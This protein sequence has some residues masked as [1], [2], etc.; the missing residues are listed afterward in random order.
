MRRILYFIITNIAILLVLSVVL[1]VLGVDQ[2][3]TQEGLN[4]GQLL[5]FCAVFG[6]GGSFLS[7]ALSK[8]I[9]KRSTGAHVIEQPRGGTEQWLVDTVRRHAQGAGIGMPEVAIFESPEPNAFATGARRDSALV[10]VSTGLLQRMGRDE[11]DAV[12]G[13]EVTHVANGDMVTL[14]LIQGVVN[15][16]V[17]FLARVVG[18]FVDRTVFR[19]ERGIGPGYFITVIVAQIVFGILASTIVMWFSRQRE[20]RADAGGARLAGREKMI[21]ALE[22]LK[23]PQGPSQL[24]E[25]LAAFGIRGGASR[26]GALFL[27]HPPLDDR[28]AALRGAT[29]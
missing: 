9:A 12:L 17:L 2:F 18:Y 3:L 1:S 23:G 21:A 25:Q 5:V 11:V 7:L 22:A 15:T 27:S 26:F 29:R 13:H 6:M 28:I 20:F 19:T 10:A 8:W 16:F 24:P 14:A 4:L